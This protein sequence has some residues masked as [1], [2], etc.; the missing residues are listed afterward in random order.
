MKEITGDLFEFEGDAI[1]ITTNGMINKDGLAVM[2]KGVALA[3]AQKYPVL[4][5]RLGRALMNLGNKVNWLLNKNFEETEINVVSFPTKHNW[6]NNSDIALIEASAKQLVELANKLGWK[7]IA[8]TRPGCGNGGL[9]WKDVKP[10]IEKYLDD[11]FYILT[12][13]MRTRAVNVY[14]EKYDVYMGRAGKGQD[15]YFGND[16]YVGYCRKCQ[17]NHTQE[18]AVEAFR[19]D[20]R[21]RIAVDDAY[22]AKIWQCQGKALGCFCKPRA[23]HVDVIVEYL[24]G[25]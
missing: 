23:C 24:E 10:V 14:K 5:D 22:R 8:I 3:A 1:C 4:P 9:E 17:K 25:K 16:H 6:K 18:E 7:K 21:V 19:A 12:P 11:R 15:G 2:G 13:P 20:F